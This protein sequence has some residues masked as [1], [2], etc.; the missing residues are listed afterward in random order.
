MF[1][2]N[3]KPFPATTGCMQSWNSSI[4][5]SF[6]SC[7]IKLRLPTKISLLPL[8]PDAGRD[9]LSS[10]TVSFKSR[11]AMVA[12]FHST[13]FRVWEKTIYGI[14]S[15]AMAKSF[16]DFSSEGFSKNVRQNSIS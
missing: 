1:S 12:L 10:K 7:I 8:P 11:F 9:C 6:I 4:K 15:I 14:L 13:L 2:N 5:L 16:I 3:G